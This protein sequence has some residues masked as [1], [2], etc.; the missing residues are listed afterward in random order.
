M[1]KKQID[2]ALGLVDAQG[3]L[4]LQ[5]EWPVFI[6]W[7]NEFE[8]ATAGQAVFIYT[9]KRFIQLAQQKEDADLALYQAAVDR[10]S[11]FAR[12]SLFDESRHLFLVE[13]NQEINIASQVWMVLAE[14]MDPDSNRKIMEQT[15]K[16]LFPVNGIAT[17]YMYHHIV[18]ALFIAGLESEAIALMKD[19][20]GKMITMGADTFWEAFKPE[21]PNFSP[22]GSPIIS[23]F[24]HAWSCTPAYLLKKYL[25]QETPDSLKVVTEQPLI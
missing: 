8:K 4:N 16:Q 13:Q 23:S 17:P 15:V 11:N 3:R 1:A 18:E 21:D 19:Y 14:V 2:L 25:L 10:M 24:C 22:Y 20:W 9:L 6:D 5:E 7:S 12:T